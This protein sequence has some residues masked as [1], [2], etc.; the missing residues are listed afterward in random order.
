MTAVAERLASRQ[1]DLENPW[2][3]LDSFEETRER[4]LP[5]PRGRR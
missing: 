5:W 3:G 2:P 4:L 1:L